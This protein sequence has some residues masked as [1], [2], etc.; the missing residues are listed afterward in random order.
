MLA[1]LQRSQIDTDV[2]PKKFLIDR[3][4]IRNFLAPIDLFQNPDAPDHSESFAYGQPSTLPFVHQAQV[5][6]QLVRQKDR[7]DF[8]SA[9]AC[10]GGEQFGQTLDIVNRV[11]PH[12]Q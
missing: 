9:E 7:T 6:R 1:A 12:R 5:S 3:P 2:L 11:D 10:L 4:E 8:S